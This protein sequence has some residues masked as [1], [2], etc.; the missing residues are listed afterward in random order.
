VSARTLSH[1]S[2]S[3][4]NG[5]LRKTRIGRGGV[6]RWALRSA[7]EPRFYLTTIKLRRTRQIYIGEE[8]P[9][10]RRHASE[11]TI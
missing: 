3:D 9:R 6:G 1:S 8:P 4:S 5:D 11:C 10:G 7:I 2:A